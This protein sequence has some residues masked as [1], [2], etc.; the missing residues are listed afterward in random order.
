[1]HF[2]GV[3]LWPK[4]ISAYSSVQHLEK[5]A[6]FIKHI[7]MWLVSSKIARKLQ[8]GA[9]FL[10]SPEKRATIK[11]LGNK[12]ST[13]LLYSKSSFSAFT[14]SRVATVLNAGRLPPSSELY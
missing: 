14:R 1:M 7:K 4:K 5:H 3:H 9:H 8:Q 10:G 11:G 13:L 12:V 6:R 2:A